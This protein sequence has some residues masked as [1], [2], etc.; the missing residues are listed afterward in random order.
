MPGTRTLAHLEQAIGAKARR[1]IKCFGFNEV[2]REDIEQE[3]WLAVLI[4]QSALRDTLASSNGSDRD[5]LNLVVVKTVMSLLRYRSWQHNIGPGDEPACRI[6]APDNRWCDPLE[7]HQAQV[8]VQQ[9]VELLPADLQA[10]CQSLQSDLST[11]ALQT[12]HLWHAFTQAQLDR[13]RC[14]FRSA[15]LHE[16]L[17]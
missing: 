13:L 7:Q 5:V 4:Y 17:C 3:L 14:I 8:D 11:T 12:D 10:F 16:Y 9:I 1:L 15:S 2:D 6:V